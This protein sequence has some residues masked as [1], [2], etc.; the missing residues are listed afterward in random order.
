M[1]IPSKA[2]GAGN[3]S[4]AQNVFRIVF[5]QTLSA[6]PTLEAWDSSAFSA[7]TKEMFVGTVVNGNL[8]FLSAVATTD[9]A[10]T[11]NWKPASVAAGGATANR[12]KGTTNYVNLSTTAPTAGQAVRFNLCWEIPSDATVPSTSTMNG[13]LACRFSYSGATPALTW[14]YNDAGTEGAPV[15][16]TITPGAAGSFI[17]PA[18]S[19]VTSANV[20]VTKPA[21]AT[22]DAPEVWITST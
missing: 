15:W 18:N 3:G 8:P 22:L 19:G 4:T 10:P 13:V 20:V 7:V 12:L 5:S 21:S 16:T 6:N 17:R 2:I 14:Q 1:A 11:S 9:A